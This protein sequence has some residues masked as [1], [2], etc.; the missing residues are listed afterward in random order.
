MS[1]KITLYSETQN[2]TLE[3]NLMISFLKKPKQSVTPKISPRILPADSSTN[4]FPFNLI[5]DI[6]E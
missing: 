4:P 1:N 3:I 6:L 5:E 2:T